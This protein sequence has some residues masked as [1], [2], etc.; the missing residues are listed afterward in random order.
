MKIG[1]VN[2]CFCSETVL[3]YA[4]HKTIIIVLLRQI[5]SHKPTNKIS[6]NMWQTFKRFRIKLA[7]SN[8]LKS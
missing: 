1:G 6:V 7:I 4:N 2:G 5:K 8:T 3:E